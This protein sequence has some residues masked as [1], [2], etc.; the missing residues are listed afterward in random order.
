V[1]AARARA[2]ARRAGEGGARGQE[3]LDLVGATAVGLALKGIGYDK[4]GIDFR[5]EEFTFA[6]KFEKAKRGVA[7]SLVL[8]FVFFFILAY[9]YAWSRWTGSGGSRTRS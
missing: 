9:N 3:S 4:S 2:R 5:K 7:C 6:G 8:L 1:R